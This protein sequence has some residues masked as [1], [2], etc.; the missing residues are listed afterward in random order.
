[1]AEKLSKNSSGYSKRQLVFE[2]LTAGTFEVRWCLKSS[3]LPL[4]GKLL[5]SDTITISK[6]ADRVA[7]RFTVAEVK[8]VYFSRRPTVI[9]FDFGTAEEDS[10]TPYS[11]YM[12][13]EKS[14]RY[15]CLSRKFTLEEK[16]KVLTAMIANQ[17][18]RL[19]QTDDMFAD[20]KFVKRKD[21]GK[22]KVR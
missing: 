10:L 2:K 15:C 13:D 5:P 8:K 18:K 14:A 20:R 16:K 21:L 6:S 12:I 11:I 3:F 22:G 9:L 17:K 7:I 1:M 4:I 19:R